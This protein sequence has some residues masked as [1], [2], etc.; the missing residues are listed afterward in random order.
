MKKNKLS[1]KK[2]RNIAIIGGSIG[3]AVLVTGINCNSS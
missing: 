2:I 3:V 1:N